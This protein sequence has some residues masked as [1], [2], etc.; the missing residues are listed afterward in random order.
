MKTYTYPQKSDRIFKYSIALICASISIYIFSDLPTLSILALVT[1][2]IGLFCSQ[3]IEIDK[4]NGQ[5]RNYTSFFGWKTGQWKS[6]KS[7]TTLVVSDRSE[8][9][10][11]FDYFRINKGFDLFL[12]NR[13]HRNQLFLKN[14]SNKD[15][16][17][18]FAQQMESNIKRPV[19][20]YASQIVSS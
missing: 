15:K 4:E 20:M 10:N 1:P 16:A 13:T 9:Q 2:A 14:F 6:L 11:I 7:Y 12:T 18:E 5:F 17:L 19:E 8:S 3:G